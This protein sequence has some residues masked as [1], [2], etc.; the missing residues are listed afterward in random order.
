MACRDGRPL[1][2]PPRM[3]EETGPE[4]E[5]LQIEK[6]ASGPEQSAPAQAQLNHIRALIK[7]RTQSTN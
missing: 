1:G 4:K 6:S 7:P 5:N 3:Q 2:L